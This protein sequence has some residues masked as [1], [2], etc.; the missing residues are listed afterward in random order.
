[1]L[2]M[3]CKPTASQPRGKAVTGG[4]TQRVFVAAL[5]LLGPTQGSVCL[6]RSIGRARDLAEIA[7]DWLIS[8][9]LAL[10]KCGVRPTVGDPPRNVGHTEPL[11][12]SEGLLF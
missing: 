5:R 1:M 6:F 12:T 8:L 9:R 3:S 7:P 11:L 2:T 10:W 4:T